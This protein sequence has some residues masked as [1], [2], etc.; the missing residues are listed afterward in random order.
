MGARKGY[1]IFVK[2]KVYGT[3]KKHH[4]EENQNRRRYSSSSHFAWKNNES[5]GEGR[6]DKQGKETTFG[7]SSDRKHSF[8]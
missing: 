3:K 4:A 5:K 8:V 6:V 1:I 7:Q 2:L